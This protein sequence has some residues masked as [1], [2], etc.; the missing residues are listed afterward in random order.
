MDQ[1]ELLQD[2]FVKLQAGA[3]LTSEAQDEEDGADPS[4]LDISLEDGARVPM[5]R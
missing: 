4:R 3:E 2:S 5:D 1:G